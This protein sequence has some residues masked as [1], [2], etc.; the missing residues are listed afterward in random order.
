MDLCLPCT[1][2]FLHTDSSSFRDIRIH[3]QI[4]LCICSDQCYFES[5]RVFDMFYQNTTILVSQMVS[6][7]DSESGMKTLFTFLEI[8]IF[9]KRQRQTKIRYSERLMTQKS[10]NSSR[11]LMRN[12]SS[13]L[14]NR[15]ADVSEKISSEIEQT[16]RC[17][18]NNFCRFY[19]LD[20]RSWPKNQTL[21]EIQFLIF[22]VFV[23]LTNSFFIISF[24]PD[25]FRDPFKFI[26]ENYIHQR[27]WK[28]PYLIVSSN[29]D[30]KEEVGS[31]FVISSFKYGAKLLGMQLTWD[32]A[33][34]AGYFLWKHNYNQNWH[35]ARKG[36][37]LH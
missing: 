22:H 26:N 37:Y 2:D 4:K 19:D 18:K 8:I 34:I 7:R 24:D 21:W 31:V 33:T 20:L 27:K 9:V 28:I 16:Q 30:Q 29:R 23:T 35:T 11:Q 1:D 17:Q 6:K 36:H 32:L 14:L 12:I 3:L 13:W 5:H 15:E 10:G 25:N